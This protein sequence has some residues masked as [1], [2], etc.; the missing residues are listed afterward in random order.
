MS[1]AN[2]WPTET[3]AGAVMVAYRSAFIDCTVTSA[4]ETVVAV[5]LCWLF[6]S[7]PAAVTSK[8]KRPAVTAW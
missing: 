8:W 2:V 1:I 3:A 4:E 7:T 6:P 5:T